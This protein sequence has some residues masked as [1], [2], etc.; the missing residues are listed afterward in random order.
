MVIPCKPIW[1]W[2][3]PARWYKEPTGLRRFFPE[4]SD[5]VQSWR[6]ACHVSFDLANLHDHL[7]D[8]SP[9]LGFG[10]KVKKSKSLSYCWAASVV[11]AATS[12]ILSRS[13]PIVPNKC[14]KVWRSCPRTTGLVKLLKTMFQ[15]AKGSLIPDVVDEDF[16]GNLT[17]PDVI[18]EMQAPPVDAPVEMPVPPVDAPDRKVQ[19]YTLSL[20]RPATS[21]STKPR[22]ST[23]LGPKVK[24]C[25]SRAC[26]RVSKPVAMLVGI[27]LS[28]SSMRDCQFPMSVQRYIHFYSSTSLDISW[29]FSF[30]WFPWL[31]HVFP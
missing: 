1:G 20:R 28:K 10:P 6:A 26:C 17:A 30:W 12:L 29:M 18:V 15:S 27:W 14:L 5:V 25:L 22:L 19:G 7:P 13:N 9:A 3:N 4:P 16:I 11:F 31:N 2:L 8:F 24:S 21:P 23:R